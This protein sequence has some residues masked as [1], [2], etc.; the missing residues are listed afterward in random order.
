MNKWSIILALFLL[1]FVLITP[2]SAIRVPLNESQLEEIS[3][4]IIKGTV[5]GNTSPQWSTEDGKYSA[6]LRPIYFYNYIIEVDEVYKGEMSND[7]ENKVYVRYFVDL[8]PQVEL[9]TEQKYILYLANNENNDTY[10]FG[11]KGYFLVDC[12]LVVDEEPAKEVGGIQ[13]LPIVKK[14][15]AFFSNFGGFFT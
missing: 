13:S 5:I 4:L 14:I 15:F 2:A 10:K 6:E 3:D 8:E 1:M 12:R 7:A 11:P 9:K